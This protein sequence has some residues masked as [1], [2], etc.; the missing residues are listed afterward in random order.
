MLPS[1]VKVTASYGL[2]MSALALPS[3]LPPADTTVSRLTSNEVFFTVIDP[4]A[5]EAAAGSV[6]DQ[7]P[8][9]VLANTNSPT[10]AAYVV[11]LVIVSQA[12]P[13]P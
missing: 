10:L 6:K 7:P 8:P 5:L 11:V 2:E 1:D 4:C 9:L 13:S 12:G 3:M